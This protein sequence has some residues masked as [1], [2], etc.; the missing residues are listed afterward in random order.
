MLVDVITRVLRSE[1]LVI[2]INHMSSYSSRRGGQEARVSRLRGRTTAY[3]VG[4]KWD[5][6]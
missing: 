2:V 4:A 6:H 1:G 3:N 5:F